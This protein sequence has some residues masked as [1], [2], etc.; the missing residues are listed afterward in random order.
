[1]TTKKKT[2]KAIIR[3]AP[4]P[5]T[6]IAPITEN[7]DNS[8]EELLSSVSTDS[9][10]VLLLAG[11]VHIGSLACNNL[12]SIFF[13]LMYPTARGLPTAEKIEEACAGAVDM[14]K[15]F[16]RLEELLSA[17]MLAQ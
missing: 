1:M 9:L 17:S 13:Q 5:V 8:V 10:A 2:R 6:E 4:T 16:R 14:L 11:T 12:Q 7:T 15:A 3:E